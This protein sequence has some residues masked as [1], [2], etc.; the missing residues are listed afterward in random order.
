[1]CPWMIQRSRSPAMAAPRLL[2]TSG[3]AIQ[4]SR[5]L[6]PDAAH[7]SAT[8]FTSAAV[9]FSIHS[10]PKPISLTSRPVRPS[11]R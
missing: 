6:M 11:S 4:Q 3:S 5:M 8:A 7:A 10:A 1:M 2:R 9:F